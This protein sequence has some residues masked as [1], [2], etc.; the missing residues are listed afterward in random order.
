MQR[1]RAG[2]SLALFFA[3]L[4]IWLPGVAAAQD[5]PP[6]LAPSPP[7]PV[8]AP[9]PT[10]SPAPRVT[11][12]V[13]RAAAAIAPLPPKKPAVVAAT[14][15]APVHRTIKTASLTRRPPAGRDRLADRGHTAV[16]HVAL[17]RS[18]PRSRFVVG[19]PPEPTIPLGTVVPPPGYFGPPLR[20]RLVYGGPPP[21]IYG[22]WGGYR[23]R[24]PY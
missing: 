9:N 15:P 13:P 20:E 1:S 23:G 5:M 8:A 3:S 11:A 22:G 17:R 6:V 14:H 10:P 19:A 7:S 2:F 16:Q 4:A 12:T 24:Y 21:G 18:E